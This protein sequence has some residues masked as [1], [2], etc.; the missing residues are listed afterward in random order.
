MKKIN[1]LLSFALCLALVLALV[2][3]HT[4]Q[5]AAANHY[6]VAHLKTGQR[7]Y[8]GDLITT[9]NR[10]FSFNS[11]D[12]Y[13]TLLFIFQYRTETV[14]DYTGSLPDGA[15]F[16]AWAAANI[17]S[18][19]PVFSFADKSVISGVDWSETRWENMQLYA[20]QNLY[21]DKGRTK[22]VINA[23]YNIEQL[24][25][26]PGSVIQMVL[27]C[28]YFVDQ[29]G[30]NMYRNI[31]GNIPVNLK[32]LRENKVR[33]Y[34]RISEGAG[35]L[36]SVKMEKAKRNGVGAEQP[37]AVLEIAE[38]YS[39]VEEQDFSYTIGLNHNGVR[40]EVYECT[41]AGK[42]TFE[43]QEADAG[44]YELNISQGDV[45]I[46][47]ALAREVKLHIGGGVYV[48]QNLYN[49]WKVRGVAKVEG[50]ASDSDLF[51]QNPAV[52]IVVSISSKNL[53]GEVTFDAAE[54]TLPDE[55]YV[56]SA[57]GS[58]LGTLDEA[59]PFGE[60]YYITTVQVDNIKVGADH[61]ATSADNTT[62]DA[63]TAAATTSAREAAAAAK[64]SGASTATVRIKNPGESSLETLRAMS[65]AAGMPVQFHADS[66]SA[67]GKMVEARIIF[68][69]A[70][71]TKGLNLSASTTNDS[72]K[73]AKALYE[74]WFRNKLFVI[75]L[76]QRDNFGFPV[77]IAAKIDPAMNTDNLVFYSS[78]T[79]PKTGKV[80]YTRIEAPNYWIDGNGYLHFTTELAGDIIISEGPLTP[81][82]EN[83][84]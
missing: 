20:A 67:D 2:R 68:D 26:Y 13:H 53:W 31:N 72:A 78:R 43:T 79:D 28:D 23:N 32:Q 25:V 16:V 41:V 83:T 5:A 51:A 21:I 22:G 4:L 9:G 39:V 50:V 36:D 15:T 84:K 57:E 42:I 3:A 11:I 30:V 1:R 7:F 35:W 34:H 65:K 74:K 46:P 81:K 77:E 58:Y 52:D 38:D 27:P 14:P 71:A 44:T 10:T 47:T 61:T 40:D 63:A 54:M 69:P 66:M 48:T 45:V 75:S 82:G 6:E 18:A 24:E 33:V 64:A 80:V 37:H 29:H 73:A 60:T 62:D 12:P 8:P 49:G 19:R 76:G 56:Y 70:K 59:V 55:G 17:G